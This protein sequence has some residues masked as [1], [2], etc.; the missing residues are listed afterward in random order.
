MMRARS[1]WGLSSLLVGLVILGALALSPDLAGQS[2]DDAI[3]G[4]TDPT[5]VPASGG[6]STANTVWM[7]A[8]A[9]VGASDTLVAS[10]AVDASSSVDAMR[11]RIVELAAAEVG[12]VSENPGPDGFKEGWERL[13]LYYEV[14][15]RYNDLAVDQPYWLQCIKAPH[16]RVADAQGRGPK[17]WCGIFTCWAWRTA[18][19]PVYWNTR[20]VGAKY[21]GDLNNMQKGDIAIVD[22][23]HI[24]PAKRLNHHCLIMSRT[25]DQVC[26]INGNSA[27]Q[28]VSLAT[29][30]VKY[31]AIYYSVADAAGQPLPPG[32]G[33]NPGTGKTPGTGSAVAG[34]GSGGSGGSGSAGGSGGAGSGAASGATGGGSGVGSGSAAGAGGGIVDTIAGIVDQIIPGGG[35]VIHGIADGIGSLLGW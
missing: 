15:Y 19:M 14:A 2:L 3:S 16:K 6:D 34:G 30:S 18:G 23:R 17:H 29:H 12:I 13:K 1:F 4:T 27:Y 33:V 24:E 32:G 7:P 28:K 11:D 26:T 31:Y 5:P 10:S 8:T 22:E 21:R 9:T 25:G 35:S 20:I